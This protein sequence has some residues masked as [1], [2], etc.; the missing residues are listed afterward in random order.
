MKK[1]GEK[2]SFLLTNGGRAII[3]KRVLQNISFK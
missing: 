2:P 3:I 1:D